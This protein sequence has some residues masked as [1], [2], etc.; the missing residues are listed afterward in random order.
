MDG[1]EASMPSIDAMVIDIS[2]DLVK[3]AAVAK[4]RIGVAMANLTM[5]FETEILFGIIFKVHE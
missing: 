1:G 5:A 4:Q 3:E 2:P